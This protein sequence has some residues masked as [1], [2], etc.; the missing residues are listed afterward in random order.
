MLALYVEAPFAVCRTFTAGWYRPSAPFLTPSAAYGLLLNL[1]GIETRL[2]EEDELHPG[3]VAASLIQPE[4]PRVKLAIGAPSVR[5][6]VR[7]VEDICDE[8]D[9]YPVL[10]TVYQQL[11]NYPVGASGGDRA[12]STFGNKYNITPVRR[13]ILVGLRAIVAVDGN[14]DLERDIVSGLSGQS[15]NS[16]YGVPFLGDNSLLPDRIEIMDQIPS[17][18]WYERVTEEQ[19]TILP[20]TARFTI[21]IDR[22][23]LSRTISALYAPSGSTPEIPSLA[24]T[25][26]QPHG[27]Q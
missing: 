7:G 14:D 5:R 10:Q 26:I 3:D 27:L 17:A 19:A 25:V 8:A 21:W 9:R 11:H 2:K 24:W 13:E 6:T 23:D 20:R 16:R 1:A 22:A 15:S 18:H 4:L 12:A